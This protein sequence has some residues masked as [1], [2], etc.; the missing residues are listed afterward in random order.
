MVCLSVRRGMVG[1][2]RVVVL[3]RMVRRRVMVEITLDGVA[4]L[5]LVRV[6][7][8]VVGLRVVQVVLLDRVVALA[9][10]VGDFMGCLK[11]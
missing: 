11:F 1:S 9:G 10:A 2:I 3:V 5:V 6:A 4:V 8:R 7:G